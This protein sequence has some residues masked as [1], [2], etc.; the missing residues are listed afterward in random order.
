[1]RS[2]CCSLLPLRDVKWHAAVGP[3]LSSCCFPFFLHERR[4]RFTTTARKPTGSSGCSLMPSATP[5]FFFFFTM[6]IGSVPALTF[7]IH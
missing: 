5:V 1:M 6:E 7:A 3:N 4:E 2:M